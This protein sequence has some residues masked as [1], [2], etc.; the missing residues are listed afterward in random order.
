MKN[1]LTRGKKGTTAK[2]KKLGNIEQQ[3]Q[4]S[5]SK[6]IS[7]DEM[8]L[9]L[10]TVLVKVKGLELQKVRGLGSEPVVRVAAVKEGQEDTS[11]TGVDADNPV[12]NA[13]KHGLRIE[14]RGDYLG[15]LEYIRELENLEWGF[16]WE[17]LD[18]EVNDY[19]DSSVGITV[20]TLSL[21]KN[22][23]GV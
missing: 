3:V 15:T 1:K 10:E 19:P 12:S 17:S 16:F 23:I 14:F 22:W 8:A 9:M 13:Y 7:P 6:L 11:A 5:A 18:F 4:N 21:D 20:Y 2:K